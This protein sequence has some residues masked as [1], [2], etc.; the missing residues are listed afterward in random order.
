MRNS[1]CDTLPRHVFTV[2]NYYVVPT[3]WWQLHD[4]GGGGNNT[5]LFEKIKNSAILF[6]FSPRGFRVTPILDPCHPG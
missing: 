3:R 4:D 5:I 1:L 6:P 2:N